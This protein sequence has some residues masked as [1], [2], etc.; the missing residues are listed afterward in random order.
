[1]SLSTD[2]IWK[3]GVWATTVWADD[4]WYESGGAPSPSP[5]PS[6]PTP[7][8]S[9]SRSKRLKYVEID[10]QQ[11]IVNNENEAVELL[12]HAR[13]LAER[14]TED[15]VE[16][17]TKALSRKTKVPKVNI[18]PPQ[19]SVSPDIAAVTAPLIADIERLYRNAATTAELRLLLAKQMED[20]EDDLLLLL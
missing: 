9:S 7:A 8:G 4:V 12:S 15:R 16:R 13:A 10:G 14:Q 1:V 17:V 5:A 2:G 6:T 18:D 19:I 20:D 11:F 3:A